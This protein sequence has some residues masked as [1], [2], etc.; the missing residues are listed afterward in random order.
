MFTN[1]NL[2]ERVLDIKHILKDPA[3][4]AYE[5]IFVRVKLFRYILVFALYFLSV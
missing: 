1:L 3:V 5:R 4:G 2:Y